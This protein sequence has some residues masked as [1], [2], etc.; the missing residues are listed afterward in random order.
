MVSEKNGVIYL[1]SQH[2]HWIENENHDTNVVW[3]ERR[4]VGNILYLD[5]IRFSEECPKAF[6][7]V[8]LLRMAQ[9]AQK[10]GFVQMVLLA[11]GGTGIKG[12]QWT[13]PFWGFETWPRLG[14]DT[15]LYPEILSLIKQEPH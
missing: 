9:L 6:G 1:R 12:A 14:F 10:L 3:I 7:V 4:A 5:Y 2:D 11:A 8:A 15:Y 13:Q